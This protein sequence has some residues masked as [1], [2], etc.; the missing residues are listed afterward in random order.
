MANLSHLLDSNYYKSPL[1]TKSEQSTE[2]EVLYNIVNNNNPSDL[3]NL[4][5]IYKNLLSASLDNYDY[6]YKLSLVE[7]SNK[8]YLQSYSAIKEALIRQPHNVH[9]LI[10]AGK[11]ALNHLNLIKEAVVHSTNALS[12]VSE[13]KELYTTL[14]SAI[15]SKDALNTDNSS[16]NRQSQQLKSELLTNQNTEWN[17]LIYTAHLLFALSCSCYAYTVSTY[18]NRKQLQRKALIALNTLYNHPN[19]LYSNDYRLLFISAI[20]HADIREL[21]TSIKLCREALEINRTNPENWLLLVLILTG[22]KKYNQALK[23]AESSIQLL[24]ANS[25][26]DLTQLLLIKS[27]LQSKFGLTAQAIITCNEI[28]Q[29][30]FHSSQFSSTAF[31]NHRRIQFSHV[32]SSPQ[33]PNSAE[34]QNVSKQIQIL[35]WLAQ[36]YAIYSGQKAAKP[37]KNPEIIL[38]EARESFSADNS[39]NNGFVC[40]SGES[41]L[42]L[43]DAFDCLNSALSLAQRSTA[44]PSLLSTLYTNLAALELLHGRISAAKSHYNAALAVNPTAVDALIALATLET[45]AG[46]AEKYSISRGLCNNALQIDSTAHL[47]WFELANIATL[48]GKAEAAAEQYLTAIELERTAPI[49]PFSSVRRSY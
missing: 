35:I 46:N 10:L 49:Q 8:N 43:T 22:Q 41:N 12:I 32:K 2:Q 7:Y 21:N 14:P 15:M 11:L 45:S 25:A 28:V 44:P 27:K 36:I 1:D 48:T 6:W 30:N 24:K 18:S 42:F 39:P 31:N 47:A 38:E 20:V 4:S 37:V 34:Q 17:S 26:I 9:S 29:N 19:K 33:T 23:A 13:D 16:D 5:I 3:S 40:A